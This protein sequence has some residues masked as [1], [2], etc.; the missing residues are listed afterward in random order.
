[1]WPR[2]LPSASIGT[3]GAAPSL[4]ALIAG[5]D[6]PAWLAVDLH[7][8]REERRPAA[9]HVDAAHTDRIPA[10]CQERAVRSSHLA[11]NLRSNSCQT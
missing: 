6:Q 7:G 8:C 4:G 3:Q 9:R 2:L 5:Y 10:V 1:M 11:R